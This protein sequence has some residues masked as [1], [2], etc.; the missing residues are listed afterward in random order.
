MGHTHT[1]LLFC[2][3]H[4]ASRGF[5]GLDISDTHTHSHTLLETPRGSEAAAVKQR[6]AIERAWLSEGTTST[7]KKAPI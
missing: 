1:F 2:R 5:K 6:A 7:V 4:F 3:A